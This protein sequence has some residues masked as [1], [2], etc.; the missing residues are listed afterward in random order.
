MR[1]GTRLEDRLDFGKHRGKT[2]EEVIEDEP[3]YVR[4]LLGA[5]PSFDIDERAEDYLEQMGA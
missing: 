5:V 3:R 1:K 2:L 4:W